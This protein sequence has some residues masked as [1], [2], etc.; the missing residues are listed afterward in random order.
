MNMHARSTVTARFCIA[1]LCL[2]AGLLQAA[3]TPTGRV[4]TAVS[5]VVGVLKDK[6]L[7]RAESWDKVGE[8]I[9]RSF[10]FHTMS[11]SV[12]STNWKKATPS[13]QRR[14]IEFFSQYLEDTYRTKIEGYNNQQIR[15]L[16]EHITGK[17]A[18]VDTVIIAG[19]TETPVS[20]R[21]RE[22]D[23]QWYAYDVVIEG[24]SLVNNYRNTFSAI[25]R[26][27][28]MDGLLNDLQQRIANYRDGGVP[29]EA[30]PDNPETAPGG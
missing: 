20:Y 10:D 30:A 21:L 5:E 19:D 15:Y 25:V 27:E 2:A 3:E 16:G 12:L 29:P 11:Q 4:K 7:A 23:G 22:R 28:G 6:T 18:V 24:V 13:E 8:V 26:T 1:V 9:N 14:F 17:R